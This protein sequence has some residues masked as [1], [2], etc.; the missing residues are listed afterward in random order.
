MSILVYALTNAAS[1]GLTSAQTLIP[2]G[3]S[4]VVLASFLLI[5]HRSS[6]PLMPLSLPQ[7]GGRLQRER[8]RDTHH[9]GCE[10]D[11]LPPDHLP[12]ADPGIL[13]AL[14]RPRLSADSPHL[15]L[16]GRLSLGET[17]HAPRPEARAP[18]RH[19]HPGSRLPAAGP[20][21]LSRRHTSPCSCPRCSSSR[22]EPP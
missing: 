10:L 15:P 7:A 4:A 9:R 19:D 5:E 3:L 20:A 2:L 18:R 11:D 1:L 8:P 6:A 13:R 21:R 16:G 17:G 22:W 14:G 12:P